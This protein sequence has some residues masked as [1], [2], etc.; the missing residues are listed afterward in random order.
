VNR[1]QKFT[2]LPLRRQ[3]LLMQ[4][5]TGLNL[6]AIA[7]RVL[8][9]PRLLSI[10]HTNSNTPDVQPGFSKDEIVWSVR[11]AA[12][13]TWRPTCAVRGLVAERMLRREGYQ[14]RFKVG[15]SRNEDFQAHA[16]VEDSTG[17]LVGS[18]EVEYHPLPNLSVHDVLSRP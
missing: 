3:W 2:A 1:F 5:W 12:A 17:T 13:L 10:M 9:L 16:W 4:C 18:S 15:V 6:T 11:A 7:I 8:P 14:V